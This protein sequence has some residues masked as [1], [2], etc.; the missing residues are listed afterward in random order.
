V[1]ARDVALAFA[2]GVD[3][4]AA[5]DGK[6]LPIA[7]NESYVYLQH[8][9]EGD[10]MSA[11][12]LG[13]LGPSASLPATPTTTEVGVSPAGSTP[14]NPKRYLT[15]NNTPGTRRW[16]GSPNPKPNY[17]SCCAYWA[18][19]LRPVLR[20]ALKLQRPR[21]GTRPVR[22]P[23]D[24]DREQIRSRGAGSVRLGLSKHAGNWRST[25]VSGAGPPLEQTV[26]V[27]GAATSS[28]SS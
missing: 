12:G 20:T 13:R 7:G 19:L 26:D 16:P 24:A 2:N 18:R 5:I 9:M 17:A 11:F 22:R 8:E 21:R 23:L 27:G 10:L 6:A 15:S 14:P 4:Q 28:V 3:R 25:G 1:D